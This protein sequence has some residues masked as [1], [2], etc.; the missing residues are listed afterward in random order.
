MTA[1]HLPNHLSELH[2]VRLLA[3]QQRATLEEWDDAV[4]EVGPVSNDQHNRPI[5]SAV[6]F[7]VAASEPLSNQLEHLSPVSVLADV[8]LGD[9]LKTESTARI[10]LHRDRKASFSV[11]VPSDVAIQPFLLIVRTRHVVTIVNIHSDVTMSSAGSSEFPAYSQIYRQRS[12]LSRD[13]LNPAR[14]PL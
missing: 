13:V 10:T 8:K 12:P 7:D 3:R 14:V 6:R 5:M 4:Q 9:E 1:S 11:D 2:E